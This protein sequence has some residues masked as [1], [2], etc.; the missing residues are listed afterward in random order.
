MCSRVH[1]RHFYKLVFPFLKLKQL[2]LNNSRSL[3]SSSKWKNL[4]NFKQK[5]KAFVFF[6][7]KFDFEDTSS[8]LKE[9]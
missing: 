2:N 8:N 6:I 1:P 4:E 5:A 9:Y 3:N 7:V